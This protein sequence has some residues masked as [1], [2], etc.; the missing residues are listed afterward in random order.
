MGGPPPPPGMPPWGVPPDPEARFD[1]WPAWK[2]EGKTDRKRYHEPYAHDVSVGGGGGGGG[3]EEEEVPPRQVALRIE[4][5]AFTTAGFASTVWDS[6]IVVAAY[7]ERHQA[8]YRGRRGAVELGAG[9]GLPTCVLSALGVPDVVGTDLAE[10]LPLLQSNL[11][12]AAAACEA[13][14]AVPARARAM[15][16]HWASTESCAQ[17]LEALGG[18]RPDLVVCCDTMYGSGFLEEQ[19]LTLVALCGSGTECLVAYGNNRQGEDA[20]MASA[21][22]HGF[23]IEPVPPHQLAPS[24]R[25]SDVTV[26][27]LQRGGAQSDGRAPEG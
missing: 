24:F 18:R 17:L 26:L 23:S 22:G 27:R 13:A 10:N 19:V 5:R 15:E 2:R 1:F 9:C 3:R 4:Q 7:L 14:R 6:A 8:W 20:F 11:E 25:P 12:S 21:K 16:L